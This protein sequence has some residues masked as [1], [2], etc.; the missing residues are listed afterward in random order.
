MKI[1]S[2]IFLFLLFTCVSKCNTSI[3]NCADLQNMQNNL[4]DSY[5]LLNNLNCS[6]MNLV[7]I[8]N[9]SSPFKGVLD[10]QGFVIHGLNLTSSVD[11]VALFS[12]GDGAVVQNIIFSDFWVTST[13]NNTALIFGQ[14]SSV[15]IMNVSL[16]ALNQSMISSTM[17]IKTFFFSL[18]FF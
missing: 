14:A 18:S 1:I 7:P 3:S 10:G 5:I 13:S 15:T 8:G 2:L 16:T 6:S 12:V 17:G 11:N 4:T 9:M